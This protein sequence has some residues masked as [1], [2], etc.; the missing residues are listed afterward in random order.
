MWDSQI[1]LDGAVWS[2][3]YR[4]NV[5]IL[6]HSIRIAIRNISVINVVFAVI[7]ASMN[8]LLSICAIEHIW[9]TED[10]VGLAGGFALAKVL[11][12]LSKSRLGHLSRVYWSKG[13]FNEF[14][15]IFRFFLFDINILLR[16]VIFI[17]G[18][19]AVFR[20]LYIF[21]LG[22]IIFCILRWILLWTIFCITSNRI[23]LGIVRRYWITNF[24]FQSSTISRRSCSRVLLHSIFVVDIF[25]HIFWIRVLVECRKSV[26]IHRN[27]V[28][29]LLIIVGKMCR[30]LAEQ[31]REVGFVTAIV[32]I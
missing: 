16:D 21:R 14:N 23:I 19:T 10:E 2:R 9:E 30:V 24:T 28:L 29:D 8:S 5:L 17:F 1:C 6:D 11:I 26:L 25:Y 31:A 13:G 12:I 7:E 27:L 18:S 15:N 20:I 32:A 4:E 22:F 3:I